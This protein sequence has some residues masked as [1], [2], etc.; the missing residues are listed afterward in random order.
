MWRVC[1][2][3]RCNDSV[4]GPVFVAMHRLFLLLTL[5]T[6]AVAHAYE[7]P[8]PTGEIEVSR[9][10]WRDAKRGREVPVKLYFPKTGAGPLPVVIFSHGLGGS[11]EGYEY[12]GR[13]WAGCGYVA[14]HLQ[15]EG[16]DDAVWKGAEASERMKAMKKAT[17]DIRNALNRPRDVS[18]A[19]DQL[20]ALNADEISPLKGRLDLQRIAVAGHSFGGFT[21][22]AIA[23]EALGPQASTELADPRVK[24]AIQMSAPVSAFGQRDHAYEQIRIPVFHMTGTKDDS[25]IGETKAADRRIPFDKMTQ[26]ETCLVI[27]KDGDHMIFSGRFREVAENAAHDA[28]FHRLICAGTTAFL[29]SHLKDSAEAC[30]WLMDGG[31]KKLVG[32]E[33][34]FESKQP[35]RK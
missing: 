34:T 32:D 21:T 13:H 28:I 30:G 27:F 10:E 17:L 8:A 35:A 26:A 20:T 4:L 23:G 15:H 7:P 2:F 19:I 31:Y 3:C 1:F 16:S 24:C 22:M 6:L 5:F 25:P 9:Y 14:V 29:D 18:F 11:R 33:G 12:L